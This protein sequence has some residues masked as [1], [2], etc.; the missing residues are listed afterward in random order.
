MKQNS[1]FRAAVGLY[2][3]VGGS[4]GEFIASGCEITNHFLYIFLL[5]YPN[6]PC[7]T[8]PTQNAQFP[9]EV[10]DV[11]PCVRKKITDDQRAKM[12][13]KT[14][15]PAKE[16]EEDINLWVSVVVKALSHGANFHAICNA[17]LLLEVDVKLAKTCFH[18]SLPIC[19]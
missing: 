6:L 1:T 8:R 11:V 15:R 7:V 16:R 5:R 10:L 19:F 9:L 17:I 13:K 12:I 2:S 14:A 3:E 18:H 4:S